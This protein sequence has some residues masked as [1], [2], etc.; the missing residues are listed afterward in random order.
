MGL[1]RSI[2]RDIPVECIASGAS[3]AS[4]SGSGTN[5]GTNSKR[6]LVRD[7]TTAASSATANRDLSATG[8]GSRLCTRAVSDVCRADIRAG[9][10]LWRSSLQYRGL[11]RTSILRARFLRLSWRREIQTVG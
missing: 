9:A 1:L 7:H 10:A 11:L 2:D 5:P 3:A 4:V 6:A 8:A